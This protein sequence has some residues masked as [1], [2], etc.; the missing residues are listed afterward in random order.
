[1]RPKNR[2]VGASTGIGLWVELLTRAYNPRNNVFS[3]YCPELKLWL[4]NVPQLDNQVKSLKFAIEE[5][6]LVGR[7]FHC[8][9]RINLQNLNSLDSNSYSQSRILSGRT[10]SQK[11]IRTYR[12]DFRVPE[13]NLQK[14]IHAKTGTYYDL[15]TGTFFSLVPRAHKARKREFF[16]TKMYPRFRKNPENYLFDYKYCYVSD[17]LTNF[18]QKGSLNVKDYRRLAKL[19]FNSLQKGHHHKIMPLDYKEN[20][21]TK[22]MKTR[23]VQKEE[24]SVYG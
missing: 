23:N 21:E 5:G 8:L 12:Q 18:W 19:Y 9:F 2:L 16:S 6:M 14:L 11:D 3:I 17:V 1:M 22:T 4:P 13:H 7:S 24:M 10:E 15:R 20:A